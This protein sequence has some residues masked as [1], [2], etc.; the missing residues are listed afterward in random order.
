MRCSEIRRYS[1]ISLA[2]A[3]SATRSLVGPIANLRNELGYFFFGLHMAVGHMP[4]RTLQGEKSPIILPSGVHLM[5]VPQPAL[6][7]LFMQTLPTLHGF[8]LAFLA[9]DE[10]GKNEVA[11]A[12]ATIARIN[13]LIVFTGPPFCEGP[14]HVC[15]LA[16]TPPLRDIL[17]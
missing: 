1:I 12:V 9:K 7:G 11:T 13:F 2:S 3:S 14:D 8:S 16:R 5:T 6:S 10:V 17:A 15:K 4:L